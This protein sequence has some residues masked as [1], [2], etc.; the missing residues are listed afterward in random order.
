MS[1]DKRLDKLLGRVWKLSALGCL[2]L[3]GSAFLIFV[4]TCIFVLGKA[5]E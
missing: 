2:L 5:A 3:I 1:F 4:G